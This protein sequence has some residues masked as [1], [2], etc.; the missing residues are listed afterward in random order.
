VYASAI[1]EAGAILTID[2]QSYADDFDLSGVAN[3]PTLA[4]SAALDIY[5]S[6]V[7]P[8]PASLTITYTGTITWRPPVTTTKT[9]SINGQT[10]LSSVVI[11]GAG[12][13][14][15]AQ[16][17]RI[18][19]AKNFTRTAGTFTHGG[20][21]VLFVG[22][23]HTISGIC[24]WQNLTRTGTATR[25]DSFTFYGAQTISGTLTIN[26][27]SSINRMIVQSSSIGTT[28]TL[29]A[30]AVAVT[31]SDFMDIIGAGAGNWDLSAVAGLSGDCGGNSGITFTIP[32]AQ[33]W[34]GSTDSVSTAAKWTS[35][36]PL[37]QDDVSMGGAG[38]T[39]TWDVPRS[40]KSITLTGT[41][42]V[43][44]NVSV[45]VF[46]SFVIGENVTFTAV[47]YILRLNGRSD[48]DLD[49]KGKIIYS[50]GV[51]APGGKYT[52]QSHILMGGDG[53]YVINGG[54]D[55]NGYNLTG[56]KFW[57]SYASA[58]SVWL[59]TGTV[60]LNS[61]AAGIPWNTAITTLLTF[62]A[63]TSTIILSNAGV[64]AQTFAGGGLTFYRVTFMGA[65]NCTFTL[66]GDNAF[67]R[68]TVDRSAAAKTIVATGTVQTVAECSIPISG[69]TAVT[70]TGGTWTF[71]TINQ[72]VSDY[73]TVANS[74]ANGPNKWFAGTH[75]T[76]GGGNT[77][78]V[79]GNPKPKGCC[80]IKGAL[81]HT[82]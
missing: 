73:L 3:V 58:R 39:I 16:A 82:L 13:L 43:T 76:D 5:G 41:A 53:L 48:Y 57:S 18:G 17:L 25:T 19:G 70:I 6:M 45:S 15:L 77:R 61:N 29:T 2:V 37:P 24:T 42:T 36:V 49:T 47:A 9:V 20:Q 46:G 63:G 55:L 23:A 69:A 32:A 26:G 52:A 66:T 1:S 80:Y 68:I 67:N 56:Y 34:D 33:V 14:Q 31:N 44:M 51:Y 40:G 28:T 62:D 72:M 4:G 12:T 54:F 21:D 27:S 30:N 75:S 7:I 78:W 35:R 11:N 22:T 60:T 74:T 81:N 8:A 79:F 50:I 65:G 59:R 64:T 38:N 71:N 10:L